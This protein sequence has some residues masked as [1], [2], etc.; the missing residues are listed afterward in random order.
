MAG[1]GEVTALGSLLSLGL[2]EGFQGLIV[3]HV[4]KPAQGMSAEKSAGDFLVSRGR[5]GGGSLWPL[6]WRALEGE[7]IWR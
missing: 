2:A 5:W 3:G 1:R 6:Q 7:K 4:G